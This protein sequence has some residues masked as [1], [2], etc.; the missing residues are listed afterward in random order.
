VSIVRE[1]VELGAGPSRRLPNEARRPASAEQQVLRVLVVVGV[2]FLAWQVQTWISWAAAG[3][4]QIT[5]YRPVHTNATWW[6]AIAYETAS[7]MLGLVLGYILIRDCVRRRGLTS[8]AI[9]AICCAGAFWL[10]NAN[11]W[12]Q[13][14]WLYS[15]QWLN[16]NGL[17][18]HMFLVRDPVQNL[19]E[20]FLFMTMVY[21]FGFLAFTMIINAIQRRAARRW[22]G[23][24]ALG[25][26]GVGFAAAFVIDLA[27]EVPMFHLNLW[28]ERSPQWMRVFGS[29]HQG[30]PLSEVALA[31][32][33]F[34][35]IA[36]LR[37]LRDDH[38]RMLIERTDNLRGWRATTVT[39]L[40]GLA[41]T[42]SLLFIGNASSGIIGLY[43]AHD[44]VSTLTPDL[45]NGNCGPGS[46][47]GLCPGD[48]GYVLR[49][50][51]T[52]G[53]DDRRGPTCSSA[54]MNALA[55]D[56]LSG[57]SLSQLRDRARAARVTHPDSLSRKQ[58]I[59]ALS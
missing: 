21:T 22:P 15:T 41:I 44:K 30:E 56:E 33:I 3:P 26:L 6:G 20:P 58:L 10:D 43:A 11:S 51:T 37:Y 47:Y 23:L 35:G 25:L 32:M 8:D 34:S 16:L 38:G 2:V 17:T 46:A 5:A 1:R 39:L 7:V 19:P 52:H 27:F 53:V 18:P 31:A 55:C 42:N 50:Q 29:G 54:W 9:I 4:H 48:P 12:L 36:M 14:T 13:P 45:V 24:S 28:T 57:L 49:L 40:A 59:L